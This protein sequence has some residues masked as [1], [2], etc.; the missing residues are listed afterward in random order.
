[1]DWSDPDFLAENLFENTRMSFGDQIEDLR[2]HLWRAIL[3]FL[4]ILAL[5]VVFDFVGYLTSTRFGIGRP[6]MDFII[7]PVEESLQKIYDER[8]QK[9]LDDLDEDGSEAQKL[10]EFTDAKIKIDIRAL[11]VNTAW[12]RG[13]AE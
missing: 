13:Q 3:G 9:A 12:S 2:R 11:A 6:M 7:H 4:A 5:V 1:M 8:M 10:N